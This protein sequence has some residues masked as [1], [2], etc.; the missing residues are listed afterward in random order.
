MADDKLAFTLDGRRGAMRRWAVALT[1][2]LAAVATPALAAGE[3]CPTQPRPQALDVVHP[4]DSSYVTR[5]VSLS[6]TPS[7]Q[8]PASSW[9]VRVYADTLF[10]D[11][12][13]RPREMLEVLRLQGE[14]DCNR[15][16]V[17]G[18]WDG[19]LEA[20]ELARLLETAGP[21]LSPASTALDRG[22][23][24]ASDDS[25]MLDGTGIAV[26]TGG[27]DWLLRRGGHPHSGAGAQVSD[28]FQA[29]AARIVPPEDMPARDWRPR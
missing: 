4:I 27:P 5:H 1:L 15:W 26:E 21:F 22:E 12:Q 18:R 25:L 13:A 7:L 24:Y 14:H 10:E 28:A 6:A 17:T 9:V 3:A 29:L 11:G 23:L 16:F 19:E 8:S 2:A 20:G